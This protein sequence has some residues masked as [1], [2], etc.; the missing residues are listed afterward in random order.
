MAIRNVSEAEN[1]PECVC[2]RGSAPDPLGELTTL[3]QSPDPPS[4]GEGTLPISHLDEASTHCPG[5]NYEKSAPMIKIMLTISQHPKCWIYTTLWNRLLWY[6]TT[7]INILEAFGV[8]WDLSY[9]LLQCVRRYD[10]I[11]WKIGQCF[12]HLWV[13][14]KTK[15]WWLNLFRPPGIYILYNKLCSV[16]DKTREP[17]CGNIF[18]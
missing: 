2:G 12:M 18:T 6:W 11:I 8:W 1:S 13:W 4:A 7:D 5:T 15:I 3:P 17:H 10:K 14:Q 16:L 9:V